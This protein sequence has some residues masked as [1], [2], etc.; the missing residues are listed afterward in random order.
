MTSQAKNNNNS[1]ELEP[2]TADI[3]HTSS[4]ETEASLAPAR[5]Q[6][7]ELPQSEDLPQEQA[8]EEVITMEAPP[9]QDDE[10]ISEMNSEEFSSA[11]PPD[12]DTPVDTA[13]KMVIA[14]AS[15]K[16]GVGKS[17]L[18][19]SIGIYLAQI[20]KRVILTDANLGSGN[21]HT[22]LGIKSPDISLH[23]FLSKE[24]KNIKEVVCDT[25]FRCLGLIP[26]HSNAVGAANPKQVQ[27]NRLLQQLKSL[28][29][30]Y[31]ILDLSAGSDYNT[32][33]LFLA[34]DLHV[35]VTSPEPTSI[36]SAF[37]F[38][39]S[40]FVRKVRPLPGVSQVLEDLQSSAYFGIPTPHQIFKLARERD[41]ALGKALNAAMAEFKPRIV[42][43][44]TRTRDD[45]ELGPA[46]AVVG[47]R[48]LCLPIDYLGHLEYDDVVWVTVR[49]HRPLLVEYPKAKIAK[50]IERI[51]RRILSLENKERPECIGVPKPMVQQNNYEILGLHPG[52]TDEEVRRAHRRVRGI[53]SKES[54]AI[55]GIA[56]VDEMNEML[57]RIE[58]AHATL[59]DPEKRHLYD[60][61]LFPSTAGKP[62]TEF[63]SQTHHPIQEGVI[64]ETS[65]S[66]GRPEMPVIESKTQFSGAL[67][68]TIREAHGIELQEIADRTKISKT[69]L[70]AIEE[71]DLPAM[72]ALVYL[73]GFVKTLAKDLKLDPDQVTRTYT[74]KIQQAQKKAAP[75]I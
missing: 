74:D 65:V 20:G 46:L 8:A 59:V 39:K 6:Q 3:S 23:H 5:D 7:P 75:G 55:Y 10:I 27:K 41:P 37:R 69:Y 72:P 32:L 21:L 30:D 15:G 45:L 71:E 62:T 64:R 29:V 19:A 60:Q 22:L 26:S 51:T 33:D 34:A 67:L 28:D 40:A 14:I 66:E 16:G 44:S 47:R 1:P 38:I 35:L 12:A 57:H 36:E 73:R 13:P 25:P 17:L 61:N 56:P 63:H 24:I 58:S 70:R 42:L 9:A 43:N 68:R 48:H 4:P 31:V 50:D 53:Y 54:P 52:A 18:A 11:P 2:N 49:K